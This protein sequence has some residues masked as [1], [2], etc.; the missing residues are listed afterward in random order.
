MK[1]ILCTVLLGLILSLNPL[2]Y[3]QST[4]NEADES[5]YYYVSVPI[6]K[7]Y[8]HREGYIVY[9]RVRTFQYA[10]A[11]IP[12]EWFSNPTGKAD[13][14]ITGSGSVWPNMAVY[15]KAGVFDHVRLTVRRDRSHETW[16]AASMYMDTG[17]SFNVNEIQLEF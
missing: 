8:A 4:Q 1:A 9:Y 12:I 16:M 2:L 6:E 5:D 10:C 15:Y 14:V 7:I 13:M 17:D 11:Y 3:A